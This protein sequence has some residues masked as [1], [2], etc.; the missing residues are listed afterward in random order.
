[1]SSVHL[2]RLLSFRYLL[3]HNTDQ[4]E[5]YE[6]YRQSLLL[7]GIRLVYRPVPIEFFSSIVAASSRAVGV[8]RR[9]LD[10]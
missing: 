9:V 7:I 10:C 2:L 4:I 8:A 3:L 5:E 6:L 1:M